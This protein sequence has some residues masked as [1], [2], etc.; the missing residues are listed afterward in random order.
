LSTVKNHVHH[1]IEKL[2]ASDRVQAVILAIEYDLI[3]L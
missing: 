3:S 2:G 1:I